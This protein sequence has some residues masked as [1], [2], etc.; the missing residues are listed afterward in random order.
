M[1]KNKQEPSL[2]DKVNKY[3]TRD[4]GDH[5]ENTGI[6]AAFDAPPDYQGIYT[7]PD[8]LA[9][10]YIAP[11]TKERRNEMMI[12]NKQEPWFD[13]FGDIDAITT[14]VG[15]DHYT[16]MKLQP[17]E[18]TYLQY[19]YEGVKH[20]L[21]TKVDKYLTRD[22]GTDRLDIEK[23]IHCIQLQLEFYDRWA[24]LES[25]EPRNKAQ[26]IEGNK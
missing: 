7:K 8:T 10:T 26:P 20:S 22:K 2:D 13:E 15:G 25:L 12:E 4:K 5:Q 14:Q 3:F 18:K 1:I 24:A 9:K 11:L 6:A 21:Y 16:S 19:G 23:A 17:L